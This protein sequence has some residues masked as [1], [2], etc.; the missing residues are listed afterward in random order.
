MG[1]LAAHAAATAGAAVTVA[2]RTPEPATLLAEAT[3][4]RSVELDPGPGPVAAAG[5]IVA[6]GGPWTVD[7]RTASALIS[8]CRRE[9]LG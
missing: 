9:M 2:N 3:R 8:A 4:G 1:S 6:L 7:D 5:V